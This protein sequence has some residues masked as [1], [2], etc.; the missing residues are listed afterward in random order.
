M[1]KVLVVDD[2]P[3]IQEFLIYILGTDPQIQVVG[4]AENG[5]DALEAVKFTKPD[6]ITMDIHMPKMDGL[7]ATSQIMTTRPT[8]IVIV[9]GH[10]APDVEALVFKAMQAGALAVISRPFGIG[11]PE[12]EAT[13][14]E[15][16][17]TVKLMAEVK[18][19]RR[20]ERPASLKTSQNAANGTR[21]I[22]KDIRFVAIGASTGGPLV[23]HTILSRLP[24]DFPVPILIVQHMAPGFIHG[25]AEWLGDT[26]LPVH[27][28]AHGV[29]PIPG[30]VYL[31]PDG[32]QMAIDGAG[33]V[34]LSQDEPVD[35]LRPAVSCLF[36]SMAK[37]AKQSAVGVLLTGMGKDGAMELKEMKEQGAIT[38]VQ[39]EESSVVYGMPHEAVRLGG[40]MYILHPEE[41]AALL[42]KLTGKG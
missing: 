20:W 38:I 13:A 31:A 37:Y 10:V 1:I 35:G 23:L 40:A 36:K 15:F 39:S 27:L 24:K 11:H 8:P 14:R 12:H 9:S 34:K 7:E 19:V 3:V 41:I 18:V 4:K 28:A 30:H 33:R 16:V 26:G 32:M 42:T 17:Q 21:N 2:S 5:E 6:V 22:T 29:S 25:F